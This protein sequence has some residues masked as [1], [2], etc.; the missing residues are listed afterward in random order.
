MT[1]PLIYDLGAPGRMGTSLPDPGVPETA[2]PADLLR[3]E[4]DLPEV[5]QMTVVR[6]FTRLSKLNY[7]IDQNMSPL[8]SCTMKY[9]PRLNEDAA[10]L[11]GFAASHPLQDPDTVQGNLALMFQLQ[12]WLAEIGGWGGAALQPPAAA[13]GGF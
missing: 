13:Q 3:T 2:L 10:R 1:E 4:L 12:E 7:A 5:D 8:G 11:P 6:H 9:N